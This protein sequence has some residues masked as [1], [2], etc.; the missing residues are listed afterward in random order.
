INIKMKK[1]M[2]ND[3]AYLVDE[4]FEN[5]TF[6]KKPSSNVNVFGHSDFTP[7][8]NKCDVVIQFNNGGTYLYEGV[9]PVIVQGAIEAESIGKYYRASISSKY[10]GVKLINPAVVFATQQQF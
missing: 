2:I 7:M 8:D 1:I 5:F 6:H 4:R 9:E 10:T 3:I